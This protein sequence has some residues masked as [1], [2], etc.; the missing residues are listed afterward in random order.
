MKGGNGKGKAKGKNKDKAPKGPKCK[1]KHG[2]GCPTQTQ[3]CPSYSAEPHDDGTTTITV[4]YSCLKDGS[5]SYVVVD[6]GC[7]GHC[8]GKMEGVRAPPSACAVARSET[9]GRPDH[10]RPRTRAVAATGPGK[11]QAVMLIAAPMQVYGASATYKYKLDKYDCIDKVC[12]YAKD[13]QFEHAP[14]GHAPTCAYS[15]EKQ[16]CQIC[17]YEIKVRPHC[18]A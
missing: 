9:R 7:D 16:L 4:D 6:E 2:K 12:V 10:L 18:H 5:I 11:R 1:A 13:G 15:S 14:A 8:D 17:N 3:H